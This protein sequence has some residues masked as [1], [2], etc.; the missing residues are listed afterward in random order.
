MFLTETINFPNI[1]IKVFILFQCPCKVQKYDR[2]KEMSFTSL[3]NWYSVYSKV[4]IV[5]VNDPH[6]AVYI[7]LQV[8]LRKIKISSLQIWKHH[9]K[10]TVSFGVFFNGLSLKTKKQK[11]CSLVYFQIWVIKLLYIDAPEIRIAQFLNVHNNTG[12]FCRCHVCKHNSKKYFFQNAVKKKE[13]ARSWS[14][15]FSIGKIMF[16]QC[17]CLHVK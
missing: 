7:N 15:L 13:Q 14:R 10:N 11:T 4:V 6:E 16:S 5:R 2:V 9:T 12:S 8:Y 17:T 3:L 1:N